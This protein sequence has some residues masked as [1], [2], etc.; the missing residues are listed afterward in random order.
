MV[1]ETH[2]VEQQP[3]ATVLIGVGTDPDTGDEIRY[4]GDHR[5]MQALAAVIEQEGPTTAEVESWAI[6][7][8][9]PTRF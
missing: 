4:G 9:I 7:S 8:R 2:T 6:L 1:V 5:A 3:G